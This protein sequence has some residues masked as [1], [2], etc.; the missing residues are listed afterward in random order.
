MRWL[1]LI[2]IAIGAP[3]AADWTCDDW[4][5]TRNLIFDRA[6]QCFN[7][8]LARSVF[9]R[10]CT[11]AA[12]LTPEDAQQVALIREYEEEWGCAVDT[13]VVRVLDVFYLAQRRAMIDLPV[14]APYESGCIGYRGAPIELRAARSMRAAVTGTI[15]VGGTLAFSYE[16]VGGWSFFIADGTG[17]GWAK[18]PDLDPQRRPGICDMYAG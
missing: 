4:W 9:D 14:A 1:A 11:G 6:G 15:P 18:T 12:S 3:A 7:S 17:M 5:F 2:M 16:D 10:A 13:S 8:P